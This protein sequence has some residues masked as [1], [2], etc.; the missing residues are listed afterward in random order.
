MLLM[1][2]ARHSFDKNHKGYVFSFKNLTKP[3]STDNSPYNTTVTAIKLQF[4]L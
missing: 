4:P 1:S 2:L 3:I